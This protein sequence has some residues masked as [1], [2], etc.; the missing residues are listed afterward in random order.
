MSAANGALVPWVP[1]DE[2]FDE[3]KQNFFVGAKTNGIYAAI[4]SIAAEVL[5]DSPHININT[6]HSY[7]AY[8]AM[9]SMGGCLYWHVCTMALTQELARRHL[10]L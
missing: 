6:F 8:D 4:P 9:Y 5:H 10:H 3:I 1:L 2:A 7:A